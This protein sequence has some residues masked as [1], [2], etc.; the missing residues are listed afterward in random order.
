MIPELI[1]ARRMANMGT[2]TAIS[3][4]TQLQTITGCDEALVTETRL[5]CRSAVLDVI[6]RRRREIRE[7]KEGV[8]NDK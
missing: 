5:F 6:A 2:T 7:K 3:T 8:K 4:V 1:I